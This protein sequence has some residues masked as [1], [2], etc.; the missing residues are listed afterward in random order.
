VQLYLA[1]KERNC[2]ATT[3]LR[4]IPGLF[5]KM[6]KTPYKIPGYDIDR[7]KIGADDVGFQGELCGTELIRRGVRGLLIRIFDPGGAQWR[8]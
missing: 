8:K 7:G 4:E 2:H 5:S 3:N 6:K 1:L